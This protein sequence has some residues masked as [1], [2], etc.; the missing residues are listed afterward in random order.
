MR[1]I[2]RIYKL[3]FKTT[4]GKSTKRFINVIGINTE[5]TGT[6]L[7]IDIIV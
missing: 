4:K 1:I 5:K 6:K 2:V 7:L 3:I